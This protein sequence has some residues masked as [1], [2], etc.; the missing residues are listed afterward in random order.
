MSR[1]SEMC[2]VFA[3]N[4]EPL[5]RLSYFITG[6]EILAEDCFSRALQA[7]TGSATTVAG[8]EFLLS[9]ARRVTTL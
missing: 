1:K 7:A 3:E 8:S 5:F 9:W 4:I 6:D 2:K